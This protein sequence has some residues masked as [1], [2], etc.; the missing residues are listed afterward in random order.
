MCVYFHGTIDYV[1][2]PEEPNEKSI[3]SIN[4]GIQQMLWIQGQDENRTAFLCTT[5]NVNIHVRIKIEIA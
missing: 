4:W 1:E 5:N 2:Y 3:Y